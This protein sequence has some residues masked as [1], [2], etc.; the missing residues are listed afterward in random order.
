[1][2]RSVVVLPQP[3][4]PSK[5]TN[6][7]SLMS[8][9]R[10]ATAASSPSRAPKRFDNPLILIP[11]IYAPARLSPSPMGGIPAR[12]D[13][14]AADLGGEPNRRTDDDRI[15]HGEGRDGLDIAGF[16]KIIDRHRERDGARR[17]Q[18]DRR[19][20]FLNDRH[21]HQEPAR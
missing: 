15:D 6:W 4:G 21:E 14:A 1:M 18:Q 20:Q 10:S 3:E 17:E 2:R 5:V 7:L 12:Q 16:V 13:T 19:A 8:R 11:A 9:S